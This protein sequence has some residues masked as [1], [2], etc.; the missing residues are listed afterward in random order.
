MPCIFIGIDII[1][2]YRPY[3]LNKV[4]PSETLNLAVSSSS[5]S[6]MIQISLTNDA[7]YR[8]GNDVQDCLYVLRMHIIKFKSKNSSP[9]LGKYFNL[10][11]ILIYLHSLRF[12]IDYC[13]YC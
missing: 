11:D 13:C 12:H 3:H 8:E 1:I 2:A 9:M 7:D 5:A 10:I 6:P 4:Y